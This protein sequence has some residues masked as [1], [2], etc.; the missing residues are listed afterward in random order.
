MHSNIIDKRTRNSDSE[1]QPVDDLEQLTELV[2]IE[3]LFVVQ[4][5][6]LELA[7]GI[8]LIKA[9]IL[10]SISAACLRLRKPPVLRKKCSK[11]A[12]LRERAWT[13][14]HAYLLPRPAHFGTF[15]FLLPHIVD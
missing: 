11:I 1:L 9:C 13:L 10:L 5:H 15:F 6:F 3:R 4:V 14:C 2:Q 8:G 7:R 12:C